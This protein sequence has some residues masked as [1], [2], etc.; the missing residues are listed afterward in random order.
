MIQF[1]A[2]TIRYDG[3]DETTSFDYPFRVFAESDLNVY[4]NGILQTFSAD[5]SVTGVNLDEGGTIEFS[6]APPEG[7]NNVLIERSVPYT[8]PISIPEGSKFPARLVETG[9]DRIV[10]MLH[11]LFDKAIRGITIAAVAATGNEDLEIA[12]NAAERADRVV[13]FSPDGNTVTVGPTVTQLQSIV[14][15]SSAPIITA[16]ASTLRGRGEGN[17]NGTLQEI[18]LGAGLSMTGTVLSAPSAPGFPS[19][20]DHSRVE[21]H[22][23]GLSLEVGPV[24]DRSD[25][26]VAKLVACQYLV[27]DKGQVVTPTQGLTAD[28]A[29]VGAGGRDRADDG[30]SGHRWWEIYHIFKNTD[31]PSSPA[32][33][34]LLFSPARVRQQTAAHVNA[35]DSSH[36]LRLN[37]NTEMA[38]QSFTT[39]VALAELHEVALSVAKQGSPTGNLW[40]EIQAD[41]AGEPSGT[42]LAT[43]TKKLASRAPGSFA[44][45]PFVFTGDQRIAL[46]NSTVYWIVLKGDFAIDGT[47]YIIWGRV[48]SGGYAGGT[49]LHYNGSS[50]SGSGPDA[51]FAVVGLPAATSVIMPS[52]YTDKC[53]LGYAQTIAN[54]AEFVSC[55]GRDRQYIDRTAQHSGTARFMINPTNTSAIWFSSGFGVTAPALG[56]VPYRS[57]LVQTARAYGTGA[58]ATFGVGG[59][60]AVDMPG[61]IPSTYIEDTEY[62]PTPATSAPTSTIEIPVGR[63][64]GAHI[65]VTSGAGS[66]IYRTGFRW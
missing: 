57:S 50:W 34:A 18:T 55:S 24:V 22:T 53:L 65:T 11:Q 47:N 40:V 25:P 36:I 12:Q 51:R 41:S 66:V 35:G 39:T 5:Y 3:N 43:S 8:Q 60:D 58:A 61:A 10:V 49:A 1:T 21:G 42:A 38:A 32:E 14:D 23:V 15:S 4:V 13:A 45:N 59:E 44:F 33:D 7:I 27:T 19:I 62:Y 52:G 28:F 26:D 30:T 31:D 9:M 48:T 64:G 54:G 16:S 2:N 37:S 29:T 63:A 46:A 6:V 56:T 17:G 20:D